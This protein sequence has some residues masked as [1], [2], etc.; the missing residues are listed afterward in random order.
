MPTIPNQTSQKKSFMKNSFILMLSLLFVKLSG[1]AFKLP[2]VSLITKTGYGYFSSA[3]NL[4]TP[5]YILA[6]SGFPAAVSRMVAAE[7]TRNNFRNVRLIHKMAFRFF[8]ILGAVG[9]A[10]LLLNAGWLTELIRNPNAKYALLVLSPTV[11]FCCVMSSYRGYFN[12]LYNQTPNAISQVVE[13]GTKLLVGVGATMAVMNMGMAD[14]EKTGTVFGTPAESVAA[15]QE[16]LYPLAAAGA[17]FGVSC[18]SIAACTFIILRYK[19]KGDGITKEQLNN[20]DQTVLSGKT[21]LRQIIRIGIP[22]SLGAAVM[23][24]CTLI[25]TVSVTRIL[26]DVLQTEEPLIR[27]QFGYGVDILTEQIPNMLWGCYGI[28]LIF[29]N[30]VPL[31]VQSFSTSAIPE[32]TESF[33]NKD[34]QRLGEKIRLTLRMSVLL[35]LPAGV[36]LIAVAKPVISVFD[37]SSVKET[38]PI[39]C[40]ISIAAI[41]SALCQPVNS[42]LQ[43]IGRYD[44]PVKVMV[45]AAGIKL[46]C[47]LFLIRIPALNIFG[48]AVSSILSYGFLFV[49]LLLLLEKHSG[50]KIGFLRF[51]FPTLLSA[52]LCG[53]AAYGVNTLWSL[54]LPEASRLVTGLGLLISVLV[55]VVVYVFAAVFTG[56]ITKNEIFLLPKGKKLAKVLEKLHVLR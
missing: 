19:L 18:A 37:P 28:A 24:L 47:N 32:V 9:T 3:Y 25:D 31:A 45:A 1:L 51:F 17:I 44:S 23:Q 41:F 5:I 21:I 29:Y 12:G 49:T 7:Y 13:A 11:F 4:Y 34:K 30:L 56:T 2:I 35:A 46:V 16:M 52:L 50:I 43:S 38:V 26:S 36:G 42:I 6:L 8:A 33:V 10:F 53:G 48:A 14:F 27:E 40:I 15:A 54:L 39:L 22:I 20:A 55:A